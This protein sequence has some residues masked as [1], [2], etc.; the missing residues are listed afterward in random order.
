MKFNEWFVSMCIKHKMEP[1][2]V[3]IAIGKSPA[4]ASYWVNERSDPRKTTIKQIENVFGETF[5]ANLE[6]EKSLTISDE[7]DVLSDVE[8]ELIFA[9]REFSD[10][11]QK[12][13]LDYVSD[14]QNAGIYKRD[15]QPEMVS[16]K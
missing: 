5:D 3:A 7:G 9:F 10:E 4:A 13:V 2:N 16:G 14:L 12:K 1:S 6:T 15:Y 11:G 8:R